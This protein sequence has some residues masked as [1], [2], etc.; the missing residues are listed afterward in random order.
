MPIYIEETGANLFMWAVIV[1]GFLLGKHRALAGSRVD[2]M[3]IYL[4]GDHGYWGVP[5]TMWEAAGHSILSK[6]EHGTF[7]IETLKRK[8]IEY[9]TGTHA[10]CDR[11]ARISIEEM[12]PRKLMQAFIGLRDF[13]YKITDI[14]LIPPASDIGHSLFTKRM[15]TLIRSHVDAESRIPKLMNL[16]MISTRMTT[17]RREQLH[18]HRIALM[19]S[20]KLRSHRPTAHAIRRI[21]E[22]TPAIARR[23]DSHLRRYAWLP[24]NYQGPVWSTTDIIERITHLLDIPVQ[25]AKVVREFSGELT[26]TRKEQVHALRQLRFS[27]REKFICRVAQ[28][29]WYLKAYR[30]DVRSRSNYFLDMILREIGRRYDIPWRLFRSADPEEVSRMLK[31]GKRLDTRELHR[32]SRELFWMCDHGKTRIWSG[33]VARKK[34]HNLVEQKII[35]SAARITGQ[36]A[37]PGIVRGR[38]RVVESVKDIHNVRRGDIMVSIA[39]NPDLLP[40]MNRAAAFVT[41][42]GGITSHAAIVAREMKKPCVIGTAYASRVLKVGDRV[43]VDANTG[44]VKKL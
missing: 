2:T 37:Y 5:K 4:K 42:A 15:Q 22:S 29:F 40:A 36:S 20:K 17:S 41:D 18:L 8:T 31:T 13:A 19:I 11:L 14:G 44:V 24:Y 7:D 23:I 1:N 6:I 43:E 33:Q 26:T 35:G 27:P 10:L 34:F 16:L 21:I 38:V 3:Y 32:R 12:T 30:A 28:E 39:T 25:F 9:G